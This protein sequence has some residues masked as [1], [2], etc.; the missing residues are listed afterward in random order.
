[1][2]EGIIAGEGIA[3][4]EGFRNVTPSSVELFAEFGY[5]AVG[6]VSPGYLA[7]TGSLCCFFC[8]FSSLG[9]RAENSQLRSVVL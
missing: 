5:T 2:G 9:Q 1:V 7:S 3:V 4:D 6:A 8:W